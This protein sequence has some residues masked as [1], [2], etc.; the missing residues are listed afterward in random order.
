MNWLDPFRFPFMIEALMVSALVGTVCAVFSCYLVLKGWSLMGDAISHA[1]LPGVVV[2]HLVGL[3]LSVGA[4]AAG[5]LSEGTYTVQY[6]GL[7]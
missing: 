2:A 5:L 1:V 4:F 6:H 3:P 7:S